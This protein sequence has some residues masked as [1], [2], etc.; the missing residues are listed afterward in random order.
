[1]RIDLAIQRRQPALFEG[2]NRLRV[3]PIESD[4]GDRVLEKG[5]PR[6]LLDPRV[7]HHAVSHGHIVDLN[8]P[9]IDA[10]VIVRLVGVLR[11]LIRDR[12][13]GHRRGEVEHEDGEEG[14]GNRG[15]AQMAARLH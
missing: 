9:L 13:N 3:K 4:A 8:L 11:F 1:M 7:T 12:S 15:A 2:A 14:G 10:V 6:N 5:A